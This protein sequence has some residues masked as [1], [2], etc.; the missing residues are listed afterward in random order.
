[1]RRVLALALLGGAAYAAWR[2]VQA[3]G[4]GGA[5]GAGASLDAIEAY[6]PGELRS[7]LDAERATETLAGLFEGGW[8][9]GDPNAGAD[10][11]AQIPKSALAAQVAAI[12]DA[13]RASLASGI[14]TN[15]RTTPADRPVLAEAE[16]RRAANVA[17]VPV[18]QVDDCTRRLVS[19]PSWTYYPQGSR[20]VVRVD[21]GTGGLASAGQPQHTATVTVDPVTGLPA[22]PR[23][24]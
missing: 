6:A 10:V 8:R 17:G 23:T 16:C 3:G 12:A 14:R 21:I 7:E 5:P 11:L 24:R 19:A 22:R 18:W 15:S 4:L 2:L 20:L 13:G 9:L 1:M